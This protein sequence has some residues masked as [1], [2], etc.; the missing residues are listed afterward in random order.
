MQDRTYAMISFK[1][2]YT[3]KYILSALSMLFVQP[4]CAAADADAD[5]AALAEYIA[6]ADRY[7][8]ETWEHHKALSL[9]EDALEQYPDSDELL[10][11]ISRSYA[12]SAEALQQLDEMDEELIVVLYTTASDYADRAIAVNPQNS[13]AYTRRAIATGQIALYQGIWD[14]I[15]LVKQTRDAVEKAL[16][17]DDQNAVAHFVYA[18]SHAEVSRRPKLVRVPLGL[19]WARMRTALEHFERAIELRPDF[20]RYRV[21]AAKAFQRDKKYDRAREILAPVPDLEIQA[22]LDHKYKEE[23]GQLIAELENQR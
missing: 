3:V 20:I 7:A 14:A 22:Q 19:G 10:W 1:P 2:T 16:E 23:A 17:L 18:R 6:G 15:D 9:L 13:M 8:E 11:R 5:A 12:D 21:D 4:P